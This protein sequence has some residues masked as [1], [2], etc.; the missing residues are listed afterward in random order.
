MRFFAC[1][2]KGMN[3]LRKNCCSVW[4][5]CKKGENA[6][7]NLMTTRFRPIYINRYGTLLH[8]HLLSVDDIHAFGHILGILHPCTI[9]VIDRSILANLLLD[10]GDT[11]SQTFDI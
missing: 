2:C 6:G 10:A 4:I 9:Q 8:H 1:N 5:L 7:G 11:G 3:N